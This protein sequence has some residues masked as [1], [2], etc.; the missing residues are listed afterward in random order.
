MYDVLN[1]IK[2]F[3]LKNNV[4]LNA[5]STIIII[6][7]IL[8]L[9]LFCRRIVLHL[10]A[11][12]SRVKF[13]EKTRSFGRGAFN[14]SEGAL[15]ERYQSSLKEDYYRG[16]VKRY[17]AADCV[18]QQTLGKGCWCLSSEVIHQPT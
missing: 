12:D 7:I 15:L 6:I 11:F 1:M 5:L 16:V 9:L 17:H 4:D 18:G 14:L 3:K 13:L 10:S 8:L 2:Y